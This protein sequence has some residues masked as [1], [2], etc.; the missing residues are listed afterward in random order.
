MQIQV[1]RHIVIRSWRLEDAERT[2]QLANNRKVSINLR[3]TFPYPYTLADAESYLRH[4]TTAKPE[5]GFAIVNEEGAIGGIGLVLGAD[6]QRKTAELG[7]WLGEPFWGQ[8]IMSRVVSTFV[9]WAFDTFDLHRV[10]ADPY[11]SNPASARVLEKNG[12]SLEGIKRCSA[13]KEGV[14][15]NQLLYAR[16]RVG[17]VV[18][19]EVEI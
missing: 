6:V 16:T 10:F 1:D 19:M 3:D 17:L 2:A 4:V 7:Y 5:T 9:R 18:G 15:L 12:F 14:V 8:G 11:S 13:V